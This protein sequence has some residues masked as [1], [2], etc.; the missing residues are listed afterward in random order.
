MN[1]FPRFNQK[2]KEREDNS[3]YPNKENNNETEKMNNLM[4][5]TLDKIRKLKEELKLLKEKKIQKNII[6]QKENK[7]IM[8]KSLPKSIN[9]SKQTKTHFENKNNSNNS[10]D[11]AV[12]SIIDKYSFHNGSDELAIFENMFRNYNQTTSNKIDI[13]EVN[14]KIQ[15]TIESGKIERFKNLKLIKNNNKSDNTL[16]DIKEKT[17]K[18]KNYDEK[19]QKIINN[20]GSSQNRKTDFSNKNTI[21][22][23]RNNFKLNKEGPLNINLHK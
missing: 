10:A 8:S 23:L 14:R 12:R 21:H 9:D 15:E 7:K 20:K 18:I 1:N 5:K 16:N 13:E 19:K 3:V 22:R 6:N 2:I 17:I 11:N 4:G